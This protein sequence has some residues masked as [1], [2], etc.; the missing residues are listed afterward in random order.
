MP[1]YKVALK[2]KKI[3]KSRYNRLHHVGELK[4]GI[5]NLPIRDLIYPTNP[6]E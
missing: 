3:N 5:W 1:N 4:G 6:T 2:S